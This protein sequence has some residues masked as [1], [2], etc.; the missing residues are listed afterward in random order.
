MPLLILAILN[1]T[2]L[3]HPDHD[4]VE[5]TLR[6]VQTVRGGEG[7]DLGVVWCKVVPWDSYYHINIPSFLEL[8]VP[9]KHV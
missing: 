8:L 9:S 1:R 4:L 6:S 2:P 3:D 7:E 5:K